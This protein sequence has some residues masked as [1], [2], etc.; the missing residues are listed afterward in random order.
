MLLKE[1]TILKIMV[2]NKMYNN[3]GHIISFFILL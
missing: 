1:L 2:G 3:T